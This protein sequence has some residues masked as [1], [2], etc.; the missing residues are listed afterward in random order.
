[1]E[2]AMSQFSPGMMPEE[3]N[4][5]QAE[6]Q[7]M[8]PAVPEEDL[9]RGTDTILGHLSEGEVVVP[10]NVL[11]Q[12]GV[13][14]KITNAFGSAGVDLDKYTVGHEKNSL[15]PQTGNPEFFGF[16]KDVFETVVDF[17]DD[18]LGAETGLS[19]DEIESQ[20]KAASA[21]ERKRTRASFDRQMARMAEESERQ[22]I[23]A[24]GERAKIRVEGQRSQQEHNRKIK[25]IIA[26]SNT[27]KNVGGTQEKASPAAESFNRASYRKT[28][29][30]AQMFDQALNKR[31]PS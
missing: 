1:M 10:L 27:S 30:S 24:S 13:M 14:A 6:E 4:L 31:R 8:S 16:L 7:P 3:P 17:A 12:P 9:G 19:Q 2:E 25:R 15:N 11:S 29:K 26:A 18:A 5:P 22:K 20:V 28:A 23:K 21:Q